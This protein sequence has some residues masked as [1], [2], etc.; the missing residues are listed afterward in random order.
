MLEY[1]TCK[2]TNRFKN[3]LSETLMYIK[4]ELKN[5]PAAEALLKEIQKVIRERNKSPKI[6]KPFCIGKYSKKPLYKI[7]VRNFY[8]I[9]KINDNKKEMEC[10]DFLYSRCD[11]NKQKKKY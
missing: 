3:N 9:Y 4:N 10:T 2:Y 8:I 6:D 7:K 5:V 11:I 1:Y